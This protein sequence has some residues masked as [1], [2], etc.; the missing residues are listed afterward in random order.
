MSSFICPIMLAATDE[1]LIT[2]LQDM[3]KEAYPDFPII[4]RCKD[5]AEVISFFPSVEAIPPRHI[6]FIQADILLS[7]PHYISHIR[8]IGSRC[9]C[10]LLSRQH[11]FDLLLSSMHC[12]AE[13]CLTLPIKLTDLYEVIN[14]IL[15][16][17]TRSDERIPTEVTEA[18]RYLFWRNDLRKLTSTRKTITEI[19]R[20]Y[21]TH[22]SEGLY[23]ALF[24]ELSSPDNSVKILDNREMM[25]AIIR[26]ATGIF[27]RDAYDMLYNRH[28]NGV[29]ILL[30]YPSFKRN[31]FNNL[32]DQMFFLLRKDFQEQ[33]HVDTTMSIGRIYTDIVN[34]PEVKQEILDARWA[35]KQLGSGRIINAENIHQE[36]LTVEQRR[37]IQEYRNL[38]IHYYE[39]LD[40]NQV[41]RYFKAFYEK[42]KNI[43]PLRQLRLF[44]RDIMD[45]LF[46]NYNVELQSYGNPEDL[47]HNYINREAVAKTMESVAQIILE[48][49][50]DLIKKIEA[51]VRR[52]FTQPIKECFA[53]ISARHCSGVRLE[54]M[55]EAVHLS[56]QYLSS[57]FHK[58]T[59]KTISAY[60]AEQKISL[61]KNMLAHSPKNISEIADYLGFTDTH[62][63]S[64]FFK[65]QL[66]MTPSNY[67]RIAQAKAKNSDYG[68]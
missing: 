46:Q 54:E 38:I 6:L 61:A 63:F 60:I 34:L 23:R 4:G 52:Q 13:D 14:R 42:Y 21:G 68:T 7:I 29:S 41:A 64:R 11:N 27:C 33:Y 28:S 47:R 20:E 25:D 66:N 53:Y 50:I 36:P 65:G 59:G 26:H 5:A 45:F 17:G 1:S 3:L 44:S 55:A 58:E 18:S 51:V 22:F 56:P 16:K 57:R 8:S 40:E 19:N 15:E 62:Y 10:V 32:I 67:R 30:N 2:K 9:Y 43:L 35:R 24:V 48:N 39:L 12:G 37:D 49:N 31:V